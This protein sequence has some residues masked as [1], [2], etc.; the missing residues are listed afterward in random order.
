MTKSSENE[1][2]SKSTSKL[3]MEW[4]MMSKRERNLFII[5]MIAIGYFC[6]LIVLILHGEV[7]D[8]YTLADAA[9]GIGAISGCIMILLIGRLFRRLREN[10]REI[11]RKKK[12]LRPEWTDQDLDVLDENVEDLY[13]RVKALENRRY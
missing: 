1:M 4:M 5:E 12:G 6:A 7:N 2:L 10:I 3:K 11:E 8:D 13:E 9:K